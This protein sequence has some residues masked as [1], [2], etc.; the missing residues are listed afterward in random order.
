MNTYTNGNS[1]IRIVYLN[2]SRGR[3][4]TVA[5]NYED[6]SEAVRFAAA[7]CSSKDRFEKRIGRDVAVGRLLKKGK[8][9]SF[10]TIGS[11]KYRDVAKFFQQ[12]VDTLPD[13]E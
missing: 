5:Y 11:T 6:A 9:V 13:M 2:N 8:L 12:N 10:N 4:V 7:Q 3:R 1:P